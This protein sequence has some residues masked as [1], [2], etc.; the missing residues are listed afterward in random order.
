MYDDFETNTSYKYLQVVIK[1]LKEP[2]CM[3]GG[4]AVY[5]QVNKNYK[6]IQGRDYLGSRDIDLGFHIN[7]KWTSEQIK[8]SSL[9]QSLDILK[10]KLNFKSLTFRLIKEIH[11]ESGKEILNHE[12]V[13][14]HQRFIMSVDPIVDFIPSNFKQIFGFIPIDEPL[15]KF[16]FENPKY[17]T[18]LK[19]FNKKLLLPKPE[20]LLATKLKSITQRDKED[21]KIKDLCDIFALLWYSGKIPRVLRNNAIKLVSQKEIKKTISKIKDEDYKKASAQLNHSSQ[22]IR[23]VIETLALS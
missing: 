14:P 19:E 23:R 4:W 2:I 18:K 17:R 12:K 21:K 1:A 15:L 7:K 13:F 6:N 11:V 16:V 9:A 20:L 10:N 3:L 5:F 22:E 8:N